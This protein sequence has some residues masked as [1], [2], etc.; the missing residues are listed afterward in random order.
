MKAYWDSS[1]L[2]QASAD[3][4]LRTRLR[5]DRGITRTH[6]LAEIFSALTGG[7]LTL[8]LDADAAAEVVD[9]LA[10]DLDFM[11]LTSAEVLSALKH[12]RQRG[13]R[14]G[15]VHDFLHAVAADKA[16]AA[17]LLTT[18]QFDFE[19]LT[20]SATVEVI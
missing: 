1:A 19:S 15:R 16:K 18:D 20:D 5:K 9:N 17:V 14:G 11:D 13:V 6:A 3:A 2:V 7:N 12:A 8:R 4:Q 10:A